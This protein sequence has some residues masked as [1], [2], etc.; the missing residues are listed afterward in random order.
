[1]G[2]RNTGLCST[3]PGYTSIP[4][5]ALPVINNTIED[6]LQHD[7]QPNSPT[8][9]QISFID[10]ARAYFCARTDPDNPTYVE[11]PREE[12][13]EGASDTGRRERARDVHRRCG[14][15]EIKVEEEKEQYER[16]IKT[17]KSYRRYVGKQKN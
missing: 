15:V 11:P 12:K 13:L 17:G 14:E 6:S 5:T 10:I 9:T 7:Y 4:D 1:M 2:V 3:Y 16:I 8:R